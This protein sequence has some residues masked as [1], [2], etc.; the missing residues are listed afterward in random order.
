MPDECGL[1]EVSVHVN[2]ETGEEEVVTSTEILLPDPINDTKASWETYGL[3]LIDNGSELF[4]WVSGDVVPGLVS[5]L[6]G[7]ENLYALQTGKTELPEFSF[8]ESEFNYK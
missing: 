5:D 8:E 4:L 1:P 7:T 3:Y 2:E 6:F